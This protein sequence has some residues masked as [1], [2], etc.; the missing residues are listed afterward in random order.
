[1]L[2]N[3]QTGEWTDGQGSGGVATGLEARPGRQGPAGHSLSPDPPRMP[4][5][6]PSESRA[7]VLNS[8]PPYPVLRSATKRKEVGL[9]QLDA[10]CRCCQDPSVGI[11]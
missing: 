6:T 5:A 8:N 11:A 10:R 1:M 2:E 3:R 4:Q 9:C 7:M